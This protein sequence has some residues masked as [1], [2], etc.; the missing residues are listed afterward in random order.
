MNASRGVGG[1]SESL[2]EW[3]SALPDRHLELLAEH[4]LHLTGQANPTPVVII[5]RH[6]VS[7]STSSQKRHKHIHRQCFS[8]A[9]NTR[10]WQIEGDADGKIRGSLTLCVCEHSGMERIPS[11]DPGVHK[12]ARITWFQ[13]CSLKSCVCSPSKSPFLSASSRWVMF[14]SAH[15]HHSIF[16]LPL[17]SALATAKL[18]NNTYLVLIHQWIIKMNG[19]TCCEYKFPPL[20]FSFGFSADVRRKFGRT[21]SVLLSDFIFQCQIFMKT[22]K[23]YDVHQSLKLVLAVWPVTASV[24]LSF[25]KLPNRTV[26][27]FF[28][29]LVF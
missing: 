9:P 21:F 25:K 3:T 11:C 26:G 16:H 23:E 1:R 28:F 8:T 4:P 20:P 13:G 29:P 14:S 27:S 5:V 19:C 24:V 7:C 15:A 6:G 2:E 12:H 18:Y 10:E 22:D 17:S